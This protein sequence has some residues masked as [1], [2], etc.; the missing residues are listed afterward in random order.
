LL[1]GWLLLP[2]LCT[3]LAHTT[4]SVIKAVASLVLLAVTVI[5]AQLTATKLDNPKGRLGM[6][7]LKDIKVCVDCTFFGTPHGQRDR[8]IHPKLTTVDL[9]TGNAEF[10]YCHAERRTQLPD[11]CGDKATLFVLN[12]EAE[13]DRLERLKELEE[14]MREAPTL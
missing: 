2:H 6:T 12:R 8:C 7:Y 10:P 13:S 5:A 11:H 1:Y 14:A 9:V 4:L 3:H